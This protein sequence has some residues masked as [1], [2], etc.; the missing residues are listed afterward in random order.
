MSPSNGEVP[1]A[2]YSDEHFTIEIVLNEY[3]VTSEFKC[4]NEVKPV[5]IL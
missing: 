1:V 5:F 4:L 3:Q 2:M